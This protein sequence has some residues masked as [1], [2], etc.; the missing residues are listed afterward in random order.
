MK[1]KSTIE[2]NYSAGRDGIKKGI[3]EV[4]I[5]ANKNP[6]TKSVHVSITD[7]AILETSGDSMA[8][9]NRKYLSN[10]SKSYSYKDYDDMLLEIESRKNYVETG[11]ELEDILLLDSLLEEVSRDGWYDSVPE[12][13]TKI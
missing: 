9:G 6:E 1:V 4:A 5:V 2:L 12:N 10:S 13:W 7:S 3:I 8:V 11:S